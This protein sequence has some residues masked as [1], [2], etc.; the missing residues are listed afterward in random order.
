MKLD[1]IAL[2]AFIKAF[3][4]RHRKRRR[5]AWKRHCTII[6]WTVFGPI[7]PRRRN[8][9]A[10]RRNTFAVTNCARANLNNNAIINERRHLL[11]DKYWVWTL[12]IF[13]PF[14]IFI[15]WHCVC[16]NAA[17]LFTWIDS[18]LITRAECALGLRM[19]YGR[20]DSHTWA[21]SLEEEQKHVVEL[22]SD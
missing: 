13:F 11:P 16:D 6:D 9:L 19:A 2:H 8:F 14:W 21:H 12:S 20:S 1:A 17:G 4:H 10:F 5:C 22:E 18:K 7:N 3:I 15:C